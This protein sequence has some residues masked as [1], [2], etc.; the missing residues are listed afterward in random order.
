MAGRLLYQAM[1][2]GMALPLVLAA[3]ASLVVL[4]VSA[5]LMSQS[6]YKEQAEERWVYERELALQSAQEEAVAMIAHVT[7]RDHFLVHRTEESDLVS[8]YEDGAWWHQAL[9]SGVA[10]EKRVCSDNRYQSH[11]SV[12][13]ALPV[14]YSERCS[15]SFRIEDLNGLLDYESMAPRPEEQESDRY[16]QRYMS[17]PVFST[18]ATRRYEY[19]VED[20]APLTRRQLA[21]APALPEHPYTSWWE[22]P[23]YLLPSQIGELEESTIGE[24]T[25]I[26]LA[27]T[28]ETRVVPYGLGYTNAGEMLLDLNQAVAESAVEQVARQIEGVP[29]FGPHVAQRAGAFPESYAETLAASIIDYA[30]EDSVTTSSAQQYRGIEAVPYCTE[31]LRRYYLSDATSEGVVLQVR[32]FLEL[33]NP[34]NQSVRGY[35]RYHFIPSPEHAVRVNG[36]SYALP[37]EELH[38]WNGEIE[39]PPNGYRVIELTHDLDEDGVGEPEAYSHYLVGRVPV[40]SISRAASDE[41]RFELYWCATDEVS[42]GDPAE[43]S[44]YVLIDGTLHGGF[45]IAGTAF[46]DA[47]EKNANNTL[48]GISL[49]EGCSGDPRM[50]YYQRSV[51]RGS[52]NYARASSFGGPN[53]YQLT[54]EA[55]VDYQT[56]Y[57]DDWHMDS[58]Y[59]QDVRGCTSSPSRGMRVPGEYGYVKWDHP[60][61]V[62][63]QRLER[64][65]KSMKSQ[66]YVEQSVDHEHRYSQVISNRG[67]YTSLGELG[68]ILDPAQWLG[69]QRGASEMLVADDDAGGGVTLA[70]GSPELNC[71]REREGHMGYESARLLDQF[72]I[73]PSTTRSLK[74]RI[75]INTAPREVLQAA[76]SG[77]S[78]N[79]D[80]IMGEILHQPREGGEVAGVIVEAILAQRAERP[81]RSLSDIALVQREGDYVFG[82]LAL[83]QEDSMMED[84]ETVWSDEGREEYFSKVYDLFTTQS[85][86]FR[87]HLRVEQQILGR[88]I[89]VER[90]L[91]V[92]VH[93][94]RDAEG[95]VDQTRSPR[96]QCS[97]R[98]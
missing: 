64:V 51:D 94:Y 95:R 68:H 4:A 24:F 40:A 75:N 27:E 13:G 74:E 11:E 69:M 90:V 17:W 76:L 88:E 67:Y 98:W 96:V 65:T 41:N 78:L 79:R 83:Y 63:A 33:W 8:W 22:M 19:P 58:Q 1:K 57:P 49:Y 12:E 9:V 84:R 35:V 86:S 25:T 73:T 81:F 36:Q 54:P 91:D 85:R 5:L 87:L 42:A 23:T 61:G 32:T 66:R 14:E 62:L 89:V 2:H 3:I 20:G 15:Y 47:V 46:I 59:G 30:D 53:D 77:V 7:N 39:I 28:W 52:L 37:A 80:Q 72:R 26:R 29:A 10:V 97:N 43:P 31:L 93:P 82:N 21:G 50:T 71:Y 45:R 55:R 38:Y 48:W 16:D 18:G 92:T 60:D 6:V 56:R 44:D 70:I 34:T